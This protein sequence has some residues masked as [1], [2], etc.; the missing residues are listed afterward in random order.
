MIYLVPVVRRLRPDR[1]DNVYFFAQRRISSTAFANGSIAYGFQIASVSVFFSWGF[2]YGFGALINPIFWGIGILWFL[3]TLPRFSFVLGRAQTLH[4][5]LGSIYKN[6][7]VTRIAAAM[8]ILGLLGAFTAEVAWGSTVISL[9]RSDAVFI[10]IVTFIM[11]CF[12]MFYVI[13]AGQESIV[14]ADQYRLV[15]A[16][17]GFS[18]VLVFLVTLLHWRG[19]AVQ[20]IGT[21]LSTV[22]LVL[23]LAVVWTTNRQI[24]NARG[25][26][27]EQSLQIQC[28]RCIRGVMIACASVSLLNTITFANS[29]PGK[30]WAYHDIS[31]FAQGPINLVSLALLPLF[32]QYIDFTMWQ[33]LSGVDVRDAAD[34]ARV[35]FSMLRYAIETPISWIFAL[36]AGVALRYGAI[37][38]DAG[39]IDSGI[40]S[41]PIALA[42][43]N[44]SF[45]GIVDVIAA[46]LFGAA[47]VAAMMST[48]DTFII[49][50]TAAFV[51]DLIPSKVAGISTIKTEGGS[52]NAVTVGK[53]A[54]LFM[55]LVALT[56]YWVSTY[57]GFDLVGVLF[58]AYS[59]QLALVPSVLG[60]IY[61]GKDVPPSWVSIVS[62]LAGFLSGIT[63]TVVALISPEWAL[64]PP[65]FSL[66]LSVPTYVIGYLLSPPARDA[67]NF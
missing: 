44:T 33:R 27:S 66:G 31:S 30:L 12:A 57:Y 10:G 49:G 56:S 35:R 36:V 1:R 19:H 67:H 42:S 50:A 43:G 9:I 51:Y 25:D 13:W 63:A 3:F 22:T 32:W 38:F 37:P 29:V 52:Q 7:V 11:A 21:L 15:V 59:G 16:Q 28:T 58:G 26:N 61:L 24:A 34:F 17:A 64:Y 18:I 54:G 65:L 23:F 47:I 8:T 4:S 2:H 5:F 53:I 40:A 6:S 20:N 55:V 62:I 14:L 46:G 45:G 48:A 41:I 60:A 39:S